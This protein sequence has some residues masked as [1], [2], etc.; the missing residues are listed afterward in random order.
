M[1][2]PELDAL[3]L[4][5]TEWW[6]GHRRLL[7]LTADTAPERLE[8]ERAQA[9]YAGRR[10]GSALEA[11]G[12][13]LADHTGQEYSPALPAE[14]VNPEDFDTDEGLFVADTLE[15]TICSMAGSCGGGRS[16][17]ASKARG[18]APGPHQSRALERI[19]T[20]GFDDLRLISGTAIALAFLFLDA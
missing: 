11:L 2:D 9:N 18:F 1:T 15:P 17:C 6:K 20:R 5:A 10:I 19:L 8:R 7:R 16:S 12:I 14:P 3:L 13:R 4:L